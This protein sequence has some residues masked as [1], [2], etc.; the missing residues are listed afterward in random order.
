MKQEAEKYLPIVREYA[1]KMWLRVGRQIDVCDFEAAGTIG[2]MKALKKISGDE[3]FT[4]SYINMKI[5]RAMQDF[6][7][8]CDW[9]PRRNGRDGNSKIYKN[10]PGNKV[11]VKPIEMTYLWD[12]YPLNGEEFVPEDEEDEKYDLSSALDQF[13]K[14][15]SIYSALEQLGPTAR[16]I[17]HLKYFRGMDIRVIGRFRGVTQARISQLHTES[18]KKLREQFYIRDKGDEK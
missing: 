18:L 12:L 3:S 11:R 14:L 17:L 6:I 4:K 1:L 10:S 2:L 16:M 15:T 9:L 7:R 5:W 13:R 8:S